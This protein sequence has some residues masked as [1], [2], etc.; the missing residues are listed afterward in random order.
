[1][2]ILAL[3]ISVIAIIIACLAYQRSGGSVEEMKQR[4]E[5]LGISMES[6]RVKTADMLNAV[7]KKLRKEDEGPSGQDEP[8]KE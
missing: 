7:E 1:M 2:S 8:P 6:L 4:V 3:I 5:D